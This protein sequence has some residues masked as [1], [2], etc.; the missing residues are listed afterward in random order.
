MTTCALQ[1]GATSVYAWVQVG[2]ATPYELHMPQQARLEPPSPTLIVIACKPA[3]TLRDIWHKAVVARGGAPLPNVFPNGPTD[4]SI[5]QVRGC[6]L[7]LATRIDAVNLQPCEWLQPA[8]DAQDCR[9]AGEAPEASLA[10]LAKVRAFKD[11][12]AAR[13]AEGLAVQA[14]VDR[15]R[16]ELTMSDEDF[17][18]VR[19][20]FSAHRVPSTV[21][22]HEHMQAILDSSR[23]CLSEAQARKLQEEFEPD[24]PEG[25]TSKRFDLM[26]AIAE[27]A[28]GG[29]SLSNWLHAF[30][31]GGYRRVPA[32]AEAPVVKPDAELLKAGI[33]SATFHG[34]EWDRRY[35]YLEAR[36][37][38]AAY[39]LGGVGLV[40]RGQAV[41]DERRVSN[42]CYYS[43]RFGATEALMSQLKQRAELRVK[44]LRLWGRAITLVPFLAAMKS[45][46]LEV[47][48]RPGNQ[49]ALAAQEHFEATAMVRKRKRH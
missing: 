34:L 43:S 7:S 33:G 46:Y 28:Q 25:L 41:D 8:T 17:Q 2:W 37:I 21:S 48:L 24:H 35:T 31:L 36:P 12:Y 9:A 6:A 47:S 45:I 5:F 1:T 14:M 30:A 27:M 40:S 19:R 18:A 20:A 11:D 38:I 15:V 39:L 42:G 22:L 44:A 3:D 4:A 29:P 13:R 26:H 49:A 16:Q 32:H 23:N 10:R